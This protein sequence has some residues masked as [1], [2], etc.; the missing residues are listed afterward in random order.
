MSHV[1]YETEIKT[2]Q[3]ARTHGLRMFLIGLG[4]DVA[5]AGTVFLVSVISD[6]E[7][8][9]TYWL[10]L[11]LGLAKSCVQGV[12]GYFARKWITPK[13]LR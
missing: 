11:G 2:G 1:D 13:H 6:L 9:R 7:W 5:V 8:T 12:V 4:L 3:A 10:M